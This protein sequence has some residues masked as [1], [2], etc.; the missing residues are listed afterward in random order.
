MNDWQLFAALHEESREGWVWASTIPKPGVPHVRL[1]NFITGKTII[2]EQREIDSNFRQRYNQP[3][4]TGL[5]ESGNVLV[6]SEHYRKKLGLDRDITGSV[7]LELS[8]VRGPLAG[9]RA[10][11]SHPNSAIRTA[12]WLGVLSAVLG[13]LSFGLAIAVFVR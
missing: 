1:R 9:I 11:R 5:P 3:P 8:S 10:G 4:R 13:A 12:T 2:C 7:N 6:I